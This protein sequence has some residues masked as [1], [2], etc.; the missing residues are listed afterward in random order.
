MYLHLYS[1]L[2]STNF[3][4]ARLLYPALKDHSV[5]VAENG[6][7]VLIN[8]RTGKKRDIL[9]SVEIFLERVDVI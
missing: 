9:K 7:E 2:N 5:S 4:T 1:C 6:M 8:E 3:E